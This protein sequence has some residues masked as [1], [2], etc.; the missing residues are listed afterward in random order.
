MPFARAHHRGYRILV[1]ENDET[2]RWNVEVITPDGNVIKPK[3]SYTG[4]LEAI[5]AGRR[6]IDLELDDAEPI[7]QYK[8]K[9]RDVK[10]WEETEW[11]SNM[12]KRFGRE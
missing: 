12:L 6:R 2:G 8:R 10:E 9:T 1:F 11:T 5:A 3:L 7:D 4:R